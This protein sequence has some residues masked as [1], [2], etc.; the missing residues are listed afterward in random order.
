MSVE[1]CLE[2][3]HNLQDDE[4]GIAV[5]SG[6]ASLIICTRCNYEAWYSQ[7]NMLHRLDGPAFQVG[8]YSSRWINGVRVN[9]NEFE[10]H[11]LVIFFRLSKEYPQ[12]LE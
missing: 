10:R 1:V 4:S 8:T 6:S 3:G 9:K 5:N 7:D 2:I 12:H 11:P